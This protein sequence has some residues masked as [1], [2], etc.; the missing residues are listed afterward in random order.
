MNGSVCV[1]VCGS[2]WMLSGSDDCNLHNGLRGHT[3]SKRQEE[4]GGK[5]M[6]CMLSVVR[7]LSCCVPGELYQTDILDHLF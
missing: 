3:E 5:Q 2:K 7:L 4:R 6:C 1:C